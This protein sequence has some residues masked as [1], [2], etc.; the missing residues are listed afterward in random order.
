[1]K[2]VSVP[3]SITPKPDQ[4]YHTTRDVLINNKVEYIVVEPGDT[5]ESIREEMDLYANEIYRYNNLY[6]GETLEPGQIIYLQP[7]RKKAAKGNEIHVVKAGETMYDIS[8][9]YGVK[10]ENLYRLNLMNEGAQPLEGTEINLRQKEARKNF[11]AGTSGR[12]VR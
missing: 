5:P 10:L 6:K 1:M 9:I 8:Q 4:D 7:K 2:W 11:K 12:G 3:E